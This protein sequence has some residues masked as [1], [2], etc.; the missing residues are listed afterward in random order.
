M[1]PKH[2]HARGSAHMVMTT[3]DQVPP[4]QE[5]F[6]EAAVDDKFVAGQE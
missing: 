1:F 3:G 5:A 6:L 4:D 2:V